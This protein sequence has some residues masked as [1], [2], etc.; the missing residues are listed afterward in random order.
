KVKQIKNSDTYNETYEVYKKGNNIEEIAEIRKLR[1]STI[2]A[3][4][5]KLY[6]EGRVI[7]LYM[8]IDRDSVAQGATAKKEL[9]SPEGLKPYFE[10]LKEEMEYD[11]IRL[12]HSVIEKNEGSVG[13]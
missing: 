4:L 1:P 11:T 8:F 7:D 13:G 5:T 3:H 10:H 12:A 6:L 9:E 2:L